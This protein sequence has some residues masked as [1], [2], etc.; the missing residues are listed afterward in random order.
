M[1][2]Q[3]RLLIIPGLRDSGPTHWQSWLQRQ[4][5]D[6]RRVVQRDYATPDLDRWATRWGA[7]YTNL[8][9]VG[10]INSEAGFGPLPLA[11][12]WVEAAR[13]RAAR[14]QRPLHAEF[15]EWNF[16]V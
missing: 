16:A 11:R 3:P 14:A 8:G 15:R 1:Y 5:R 10:H 9:D 12:R 2:R 13:S 6:A 4:Y 7:H